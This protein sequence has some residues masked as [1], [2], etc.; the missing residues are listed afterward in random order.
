MKR[1]RLIGRTFSDK[2]GLKYKISESGSTRSVLVTEVG[3]HIAT[4]SLWSVGEIAAR[5]Q[6]GAWVLDNYEPKL[7][8]GSSDYYTVS[9]KNPTTPGKA[10]YEA[11]CNDIIEALNMSFAEGNVFKA[12]WRKAALKMGQGKH[13]TTAL[14]DA[15]KIVF[16][17]NRQV[18]QESND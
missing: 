17:G 12:Q 5:L 4:S 13:G 15:E 3:K 16:F 18:V 2:S 1:E 7:T 9:I 14:Y 11:E 6:S 10:P 8:G